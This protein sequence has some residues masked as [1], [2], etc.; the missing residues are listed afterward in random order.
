MSDEETQEQAPRRTIVIGDDA[1]AQPGSGGPVD[2]LLS[3]A[4]PPGDASTEV[5]VREPGLGEPA[6]DAPEPAPGERATI[7]IASDDLPDASYANAV[8]S[9]GS[10][11][12]RL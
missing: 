4:A 8:P 7:V 11:P 2:P 5:W 6:Q 12:N 9:H 3:A 10:R 1:G